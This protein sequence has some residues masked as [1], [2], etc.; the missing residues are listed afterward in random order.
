M[1]RIGNLKLFGFYTDRNDVRRKHPCISM[2][3]KEP[4]EMVLK[5]NADGI[6]IRNNKRSEIGLTAEG[7][8]AALATA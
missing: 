2:T 5:A 1:G 3:G 4:M 6:A 8:R 7:I